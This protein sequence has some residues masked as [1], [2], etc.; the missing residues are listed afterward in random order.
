MDAANVSNCAHRPRQ[1][2]QTKHTKQNTPNKTRNTHREA[3]PSRDAGGLAVVATVGRVASAARGGVWRQQRVGDLA[4]A[5]A[6]D[7]REP[8]LP[9]AIGV[10]AEVGRPAL[11]TR[12]A[13]VVSFFFGGGGVVVVVMGVRVSTPPSK[14]EQAS[15]CLCLRVCVCVS[16][17]VCLCVCLYVC[18]VS[19][20]VCC[21]YREW[22]AADVH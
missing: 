14:R 11:I 4:P 18:A 21:V 13:P 17:S 9:L 6:P 15:V 20:S 12:A 1:T 5:L 2:N 7:T 19:V 22:E 8:A 10:A 3:L 16:V